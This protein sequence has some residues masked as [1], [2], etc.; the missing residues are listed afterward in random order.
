MSKKLFLQTFG[1]PLPA[2]SERSESNGF[3]DCETSPPKDG[4]AS[5][6]AGSRGNYGFP[7]VGGG[8][9]GYVKKINKGIPHGS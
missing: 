2:L 4:P 6:V 8:V 5:F 7:G 1:W 3:R 9:D